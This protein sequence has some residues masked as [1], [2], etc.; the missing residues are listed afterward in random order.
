MRTHSLINRWMAI[1][2]QFD[3][4]SHHF[5]Q[6]FIFA[7]GLFI[8]RLW[9]KASIIYCI[10]NADAHNL[11]H[12]FHNNID[13]NSTFYLIFGASHSIV[14]RKKKMFM[15]LIGRAFG[16]FS[17]SP[18]VYTSIRHNK[19]WYTVFICS[20]LDANFDLVFAFLFLI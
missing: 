14:K 1:H 19:F 18:Y 7:I 15:I 10:S 4:D 17:F 3:I 9:C 5:L 13:F 2:K 6:Q 11:N 16:L 12:K 20:F 8:Q